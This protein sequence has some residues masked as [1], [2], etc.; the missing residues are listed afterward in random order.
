MQLTNV[1]GNGIVAGE[2]NKLFGKEGRRC[3]AQRVNG[4]SEGEGRAAH[5]GRKIA[6][7]RRGLQGEDESWIDVSS[8]ERDI[9]G[10][11]SE[12]RAIHGVIPK[13]MS[14]CSLS[15]RE[16]HYFANLHAFPECK[17]YHFRVVE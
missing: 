6:Q 17:T 3:A 1:M 11:Y 9:G 7:G 15:D 4:E 16:C 10:A 13:V 12:C 2:G 14:R 8:R 5:K